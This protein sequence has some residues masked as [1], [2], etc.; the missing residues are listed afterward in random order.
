MAKCLL[1]QFHLVHASLTVAVPETGSS[2]GLAQLNPDRNNLT[3]AS[4]DLAGH[5]R[6]LVLVRSVHCGKADVVLLANAS[7][8]VASPLAD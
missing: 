1:P 5:L 6:N 3:A 2:E 7:G 8:T 4:G